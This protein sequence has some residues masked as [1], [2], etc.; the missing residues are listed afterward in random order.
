MS[1]VA[2]YLQEHLLGEVMTSADALAYFSTDGSVLT[3]RPS[4]IVYPRNENDV[5]KAARF[6]WQLAERGRVLPITARGSGTDQGGA[7]LGP[8]VL[9]V[10]PAHM[11]RIVML[12]A[13]NGLVTVEPGT[14]FGKLQQTL[15]TH[16]RFLPAYPASLEYSTIGG[17]VA[18]NASGERSLKYGDTNGFVKSLKVVLANGEI[19]QTGRLTKRELSKKL[20][21]TTFEGEVY[22]AV[23]TLIEEHH[24]VIAKM[25]PQTTR[26]TAGYNL[27]AVKNKDGFDLTPLFV[28]S[29]GTLGI[30]TEVTLE[31]E[32]Y[33]PSTT[34]IVSMFDDSASAQAA[35]S[36]LRALSDMPCA[37]EMI[38]DKLLEFINQVNPNQLR[39]VV[40]PP[41]PKA[42]LLV[43]FDDANEHAQKKMARQAL[44]I[45]EKH[46]TTRQVAAN[47]T[48]QAQLWKLR[49]AAATAIAYTEG[50]LKAVPFID[51]GIVP[52]DKFADYLDGIYEMLER[53]HV[54]AA[55]WGHAGDANLHL[56]PHLDL[57]QV[58]DRQK[59]FRLMDEYYGMIIDLGGSTS[60]GHG[61]GRL[62]AAYLPKLYGEEA[63]ALLQKIKTIF[64]PHGM[65]N[66]GVKIGVYIDDVKPLLRHEY[67]LGAWYEHMPRH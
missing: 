38:D 67:N 16:G 17:A 39:D 7:A 11:N 54:R 29:Q 21:L 2:H 34:L 58:G 55:V 52:V 3:I 31:T 40:A 43:E 61:D 48:E 59:L 4:T 1:K 51:D 20:G 13:K 63:Y 27:S 50:A 15:M 49:Q 35:I 12:D 22:R 25:A 47:E 62:R 45:L 14:N 42:I 19:I 6:S 24:D 37:I 46:A 36:Q 32:T 5:R 44:K 33:S 41:Y 10:F 8:G 9:L 53:N 18:N 28:G 60:G 56:Q 26:N 64:D 30:I 65:L 23:D 57:A 66:P